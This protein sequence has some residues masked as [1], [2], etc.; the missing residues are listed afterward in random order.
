MSSSAL[1]TILGIWSV[2]VILIMLERL[3]PP[4]RQ[5]RQIMDFMWKV[6][7]TKTPFFRKENH[8]NDT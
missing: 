1:L 4:S 6:D 7:A 2:G 8:A 5:E 3:R